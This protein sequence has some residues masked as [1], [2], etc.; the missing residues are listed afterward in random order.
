M[1][2]VRIVDI[3]ADLD[4][5]VSTV[6]KALAGSREISPETTERVRARAEALGY[7]PNG[8]AR[9]LRTGRT[10]AIGLI[11]HD[12]IAWQSLPVL[13]GA[14]D[15]FGAEE[16]SV[17]LSDSR[18][19]PIRTKHHIRTLLEHGIDGIIAL[20]ENTN[21][22]PSLGNLSVPVVYA[23]G[24]ST[25][26]ADLSVVPDEY[27]GAESAVEFL[28][29]LGR[30]RIGHIT[31]PTS[32]VATS[33][34]AAATESVLRRYGL[35]LAGGRCL[36]GE[37]TEAW[38]RAGTELLLQRE[39]EVDAI[40]C[41]NDMIARGALDTLARRGRRVPD[42]VAIVGYDNW[43]TIASDANP[44]LTTI[45]MN[46]EVVGKT[47]AAALVDAIQGNPRHGIERVPCRLITRQSTV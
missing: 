31:G 44:P 19:D 14:Q 35:P 11:T 41:G 5:S 42:D 18:G 36:S 25:D 15:A 37:W 46:L 8:A 29:G 26:P 22:Q 34:R 6:S 7:R 9:R 16:W 28:V 32:Y 12:S 21:S 45:D 38:G 27:S 4:V 40:F 39:P 3:A 47:A 10:R 24:T 1:A 30:T 20:A 33:R 43:E 2:Q 13:L 17:L 23:Y